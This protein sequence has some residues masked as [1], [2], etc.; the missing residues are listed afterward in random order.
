MMRKKVYSDILPHFAH[1]LTKIFLSPLQADIFPRLCSGL[2]S[3]T[4]TLLICSG[5]G[6]E[7]DIR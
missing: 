3:K 1:C 7:H 2:S 5:A 4:A 6:E